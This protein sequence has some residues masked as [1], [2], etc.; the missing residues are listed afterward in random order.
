[1][2]QRKDKCSWKEGCKKAKASRAFTFALVERIVYYLLTGNEVVKL[3]KYSWWSEEVDGLHGQSMH[4]LGIF[5]L[6]YTGTVPL[7][8]PTTIAKITTAISKN[9][10]FRSK[11]WFLDTSHTPMGK[12]LKLTYV[13][14]F[15][16][17]IAHSHLE[18]QDREG[19]S[20]VSW[21]LLG[22]L[23][24]KTSRIVASH[25]DQFIHG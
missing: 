14:R 4:K 23:I 18:E 21:W 15:W 6:Y 22:K 17:Q 13:K 24:D 11:H 9:V 12:N 20:K 2:Q 5:L 7:K 10:L 8:D 16:M 3:K 1:M 19:I 25:S